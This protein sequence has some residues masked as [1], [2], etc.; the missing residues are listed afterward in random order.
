MGTFALHGSPTIPY[1]NCFLCMG[2][3]H[4]RA[5]KVVT[6]TAGFGGGF[7]KPCRNPGFSGTQVFQTLRPRDIQILFVW[8][9][10]PSR[11]RQVLEGVFLVLTALGSIARLRHSG[12]KLYREARILGDARSYLPC[13]TPPHATTP[14]AGMGF[15]SARYAYRIYMPDVHNPIYISDRHIRSAGRICT[16]DMQI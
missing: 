7:Q 15:R 10:S 6:P 1:T 2:G 4:K 11:P 5:Y 16:S 13:P 3:R 14:F 9:N 12:K 8:S